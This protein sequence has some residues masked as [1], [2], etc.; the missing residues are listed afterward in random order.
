M[1]AYPT[2][3]TDRSTNTG[4]AALVK[5]CSLQVLPRRPGPAPACVHSP[6][7]SQACPCSMQRALLPVGSCVLPCSE[8]WGSALQCVVQHIQTSQQTPLLAALGN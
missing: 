3:V 7:L 8:M 1:L 5:S 4:S 6:V 2:V